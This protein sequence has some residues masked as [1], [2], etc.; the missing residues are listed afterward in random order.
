MGMSLMLDR[1]GMLDAEMLNAHMELVGLGPA[2][3]HPNGVKH[4]YSFPHISN[5]GSL[6]VTL[7]LAPLLP[8]F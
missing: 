8:L 1:L 4:L 5:F 3:Y 6:N 2:E 7:L